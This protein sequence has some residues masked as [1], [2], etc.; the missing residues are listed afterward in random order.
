MVAESFASDLLRSEIRRGHGVARPDAV[1]TP[2][3]G[4]QRGCAHSDILDGLEHEFPKSDH[5]QIGLAEQFTRA[6]GDGP[7]AVGDGLVLL[8][9]AGDAGETRRPL[10]FPVEEIVVLAAPDR[11]EIVVDLREYA[12]TAG[13]AFALPLLDRSIRVPRVAEIQQEVSSM[14][15]Q[16][17]ASAVSSGKAPGV[18]E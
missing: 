6:V 13:K 11:H 3:V 15:T 18:S 14:G 9:D 12:R 17:L 7:L 1:G 16:V 10:L 2:V 8:R 5:A 4:T